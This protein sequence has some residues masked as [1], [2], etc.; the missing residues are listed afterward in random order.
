MKTKA[1]LFLLVL[2]ASIGAAR[3]Q[4]AYDSDY[5][6][7]A[8]PVPAVVYQAPVTYAAPVVYQAPVIYYAPVFYGNAMS[9]AMNAY[10]ACQ[11]A[12][13]RCQARSTVT[14]IG[15][16]QTRFQVSPRCNYG[17][18]VTYIGGSWYSSH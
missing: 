1:T 13:A 15:G 5:P 2:T 7:A 16:G 14:Y 11:D 8:V 9:C 10:A 18:T 4:D 17:S 6:T 12:A 3:A